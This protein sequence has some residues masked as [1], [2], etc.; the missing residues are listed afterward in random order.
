M[1]KENYYLYVTIYNYR[2]AIVES[3]EVLDDY[4]SDGLEELLSE[5]EENDELEWVN[6]FSSQRKEPTEIENSLGERNSIYFNGKKINLEK[7]SKK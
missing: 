3:E 5:L 7:M 4:D 1:T 6:D 2:H